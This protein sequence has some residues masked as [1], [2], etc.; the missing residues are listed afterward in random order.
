MYVVD[1]GS[2]PIAELYTT[3]ASQLEALLPEYLGAQRWF[4]GK[5]H[6][7]EV[8]KDAYLTNETN[9]AN[10]PGMFG[11]IDHAEADQLARTVAVMPDL[12]PNDGDGWTHAL[13]EVGDVLGASRIVGAD[14]RAA[15]AESDRETA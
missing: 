15:V 4:A 10:T 8:W 1:L 7:L 13:Q 2:R 3:G 5:G 9:F 12:A 11:S 14:T 6:T